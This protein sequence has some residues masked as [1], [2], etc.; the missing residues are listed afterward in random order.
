MRET[1]VA[2]LTTEK[3]TLDAKVT[4]LEMVKDARLSPA[5]ADAAKAYAQVVD[6]QRR[7]A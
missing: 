7:S 4:T 5:A 6:R 2:T 1:Q 3:S